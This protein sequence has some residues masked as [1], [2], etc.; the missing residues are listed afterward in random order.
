VSSA[1]LYLAIVAIWA[2]FLVPAWVRRPHA[3]RA[4]SAAEQ[5]DAWPG[6]GE[7]A[8]THDERAHGQRSHGERVHDRGHG[9]AETAEYE[10]STAAY[11]AEATEY[12][13]NTENDVEVSLQADIHVEVNRRNQEYRDGMPDYDGEHPSHQGGGPDGY[14]DHAG[15]VRPRTRPSQSREQML[16]ARRRMLTMLLAMTGLTCGFA[17]LGAAQWW[18]CAPPAGMLVLYVLLLREIAM[19]DAEQARRRHAWAAREARLARQRAFEERTEREAWRLG[20][21]PDSADTGAQIIDIS[22]R[23]GDQLYDQYADAAVRAVGD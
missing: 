6:D 14:Y 5:D 2:G 23:V 18:I 7:H 17:L 21:R 10:F 13:T 9:H 19:A 22:G 11:A 20:P 16:R 8:D 12:P 1:I 4:D 3:A 15:P